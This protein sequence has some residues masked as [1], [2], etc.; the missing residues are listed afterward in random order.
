VFAC[1][2]LLRSMGDRLISIEKLFFTD[3]KLG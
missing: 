3:L 2:H 1:F